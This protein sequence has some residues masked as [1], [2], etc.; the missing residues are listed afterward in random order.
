[1][2][3]LEDA[4]KLIGIDSTPGHGNLAAAEFCARICEDAGL[5]VEMQKENWDGLDQC[6]LIARPPGKAPSR[7]F[8]LQT[9]LDTVEAGH[10]S[11]WNKTQSNPFNASIYENEIYG[12]GTADAKLDFLCK[13]AAISQVME[14]KPSWKLPPVLVGTY[15]AQSGMAGAIKLIRRK[16]IQAVQA[17]VGEPTEMRLSNAGTGHA[18]VEIAV[19]FSEHERTYR[20]DHDLM[21]STTSQ[22]RYFSGRAAHSADPT[23]GENAIMKML[24]YLTQLP[25]GIVVMDLS[26]G[27]NDNS[28][29]ASAF[30]E[31]DLVAGCKDPLLPKILKIYSSLQTLQTRLLEFQEVGM[32]PPHA[33]MNIGRIRT[34]EAE[35][36]L[37]GSCRLPPSVTDSVYQ[38]WMSDLDSAVREGGATFRVKDYRRGF[39]TP[40][41]TKFVQQAQDVLN[42]MGLGSQLAKIALTS[43]ANV[44]ARLGV[45]CLVWGPGQS[46]GNSHAPNERISIKD[47]ELAVEFYR[48]VIERVCL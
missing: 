22:S 6:N 12:L 32:K 13:I 29:P 18:I 28:V 46:V 10:F 19:P 33:T 41:N 35:V 4:R 48:R 37:S 24:E 9:H 15:G 11:H 31:V 38:A 44:F 26:G 2:K 21:E 25:E 45:E 43:E 27:I 7:E 20:R 14:K 17:L 39:Q 42:D 5:S 40:E 34:N 3:F 36:V 47:L 30:L 8:L 16:K 23:L 1:M